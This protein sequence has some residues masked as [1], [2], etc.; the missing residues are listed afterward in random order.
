MWSPT[1]DDSFSVESCIT[2]QEEGGGEDKTV[3]RQQ[4]NSIAESTQ[5]G[6]T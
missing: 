3:T 1:R 6:V 2:Q 4:Q 5:K